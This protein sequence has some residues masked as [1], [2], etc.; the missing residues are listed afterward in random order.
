[1]LSR[2]TITSVAVVGLATT[3]FT[4]TVV[5][6]RA[7]SAEPLIWLS[8][9]SWVKAPLNWRRPPVKVIGID[10]GVGRFAPGSTVSPGPPKTPSPLRSRSAVQSSG[11]AAP[12]AEEV[13]PAWLIS[14][15]TL[16]TAAVRKPPRL[17]V[18]ARFEPLTASQYRVSVPVAGVGASRTA[19]PMSPPETVR[20][21]PGVPV[22]AWR[23]LSPT[24]SSVAPVRVVPPILALTVVWLMAKLAEP[25]IRL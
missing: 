25:V 24:V 12:L 10:T 8:M 23:S 7:K 9:L 15:V 6:L 5:T 21:N 3:P 4:W 2:A 14:I 20:P 1:M 17:N 19:M 18:A 11:A 22:P 13:P 16:L